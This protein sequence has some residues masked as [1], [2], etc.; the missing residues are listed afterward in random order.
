MIDHDI[1]ITWILGD[2]ASISV[3]VLAFLMAGTYLLQLFLPIDPIYYSKPIRR[4]R[5]LLRALNWGFFGMI[6]LLFGH[7]INLHDIYLWRA[8][9][10]LALI[11]LILSELAYQ[12]IVL[13]PALKKRI[14]WKRSTSPLSS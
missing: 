8:T 12:L 6:F 13:W 9:A 2:Q 4:D 1:F 11:F 14:S 10:R 7:V 3:S 5:I